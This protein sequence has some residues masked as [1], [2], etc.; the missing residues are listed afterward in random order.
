MSTD[1][2]TYNGF[3]ATE[4]LQAEIL[5]A[6]TFSI[7]TEIEKHPLA[8]L[9]HVRKAP[10]L[11]KSSAVIKSDADVVRKSTKYSDCRNH[12]RLNG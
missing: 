4:A 3:D 10:K 11:P 1:R 6:D 8:M 2:A 7:A 9:A 5:G 12:V